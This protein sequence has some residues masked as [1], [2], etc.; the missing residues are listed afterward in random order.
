MSGL[1]QTR[2]SRCHRDRVRLGVQSGLEGIVREKGTAKQVLANL[3][4]QAAQSS[5]HS[6]KATAR[7]SLKRLRGTP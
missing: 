1:G 7:F 3:A 4:C 6:A 5:R 2:L